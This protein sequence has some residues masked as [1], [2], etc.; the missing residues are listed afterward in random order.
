MDFDFSFLDDIDLNV[1]DDLINYD[2]M[3]NDLVEILKD[4]YKLYI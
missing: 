3:L 1:S 4:L 2:K